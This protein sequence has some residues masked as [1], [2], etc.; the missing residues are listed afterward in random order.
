MPHLDGGGGR[1]R[2]LEDHY[3]MSAQQYANTFAKLQG[4]CCPT[5]PPYYETG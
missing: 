3:K 1:I 5:S 4:V 2:V